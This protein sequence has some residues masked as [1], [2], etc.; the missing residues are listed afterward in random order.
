MFNFSSG[1]VSLPA[2]RDRVIKDEKFRTKRR[3][4]VDRTFCLIDALVVRTA[5]KDVSVR[6]FA[7]LVLALLFNNADEESKARLLKRLDHYQV[8]RYKRDDKISLKDLSAV[9]HVYIQYPQG[10]WVSDLTELDGKLLYHKPDD[11][12]ELQAALLAQENEMVLSVVRDNT[13]RRIMEADMVTAYLEGVNCLVTDLSET[14][15]V[16]GK[17]RSKPVPNQVR[18]EVGSVI[19]FIE[20]PGL[21]NKRAWKVG[22]ETWINLGNP[23]MHE[24]YQEL[25]NVEADKTKLSAVSILFEIL[26]Y[27]F[28]SAIKEL[29]GLIK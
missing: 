14:N 20:V 2:G 5:S 24:V 26:S 15:V 13:E 22:N 29:M 7:A 25:Q 21:P 1:A 11:F 18:Q 12:V 28:D 3:L 19:K 17:Y 8:R 4:I 9:G 27:R 10:N 23:S 16:E 6:D